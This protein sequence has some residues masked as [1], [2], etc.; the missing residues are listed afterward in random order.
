MGYIQAMEILPERLIEEI[1]KY[2]DG[3]IIYIPKL[4]SRRC[5]WGEKTNSK[6]Y[7]KE[8]NSEIYHSYINGS[9]VLELSEK[10]FLAP[11]SIQRIIRDMKTI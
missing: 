5:K 2:I 9:T 6:A 3:Q 7:F 10:Y 8:R 4:K 1:Q 11:K